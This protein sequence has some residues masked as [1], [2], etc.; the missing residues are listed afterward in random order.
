[1]VIIGVYSLITV[2]IYCLLDIRSFKIKTLTKE[3]FNDD[4]CI[5]NV[6]FDQRNFSKYIYHASRID[7]GR[8]LA[9]NIVYCFIQIFIM[10]NFILRLL[11]P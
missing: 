4:V 6:I 8:I 10:F 7:I 9:D 11:T 1:M 2:Y 5:C 3:M